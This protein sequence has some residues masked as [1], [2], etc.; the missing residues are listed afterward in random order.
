MIVRTS[1]ILAL[2]LLSTVPALVLSAPSS[3]QSGH[4][5][6][7]KEASTIARP[8]LR[9]STAHRGIRLDG[10]LDDP[11]WGAADSVELTQ[12]EPH[13]RAAPT[14]R[15]VVRV[16]ATPNAI[17]IGIRADDPEPGRIVAFARQRDASLSNE[18]HVKI[19]LDTYADGR[20]GYV[21]AVNPNGARYAEVSR[22]PARAG[23]ATTTRAST[24]R[25]ASVPIRSRRSR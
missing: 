7:K 3:A 17:I 16:L 24:P 14:G 18:D 15:T 2:A 4:E 10:R 22:L 13:E 25:S 1:H 23:G 5:P 19:V 11:A 12:V 9:V 20:S 8:H 6:S 21:F